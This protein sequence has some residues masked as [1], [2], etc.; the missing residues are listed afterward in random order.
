MKINNTKANKQ[1]VLILFGDALQT[2]RIQMAQ[3]RRPVRTTAAPSRLHCG[4]PGRWLPR[5][6]AGGMVQNCLRQVRLP[7]SKQP[8]I[9]PAFQLAKAEIDSTPQLHLITAPWFVRSSLKQA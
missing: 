9:W 5:D 6:A 1:Q 8:P 4:R 7:N 2:P 3:M